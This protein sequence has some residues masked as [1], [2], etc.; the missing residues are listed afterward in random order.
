MIKYTFSHLKKVKQ[1]HFVTHIQGITRL[2]IEGSVQEMT[3]HGAGGYAQVVGGFQGVVAV[4]VVGGVFK[5]K[6][7]FDV[8]LKNV[9]ISPNVLGVGNFLSKREK[10]ETVEIESKS[11]DSEAV[12]ILNTCE[13]APDGFVYTEFLRTA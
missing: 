3:V 2:T 6:T 9:H 12:F 13:A 1:I 7:A 4:V 10:E 8:V 5:G 11:K